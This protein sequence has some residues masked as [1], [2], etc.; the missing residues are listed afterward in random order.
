MEG[1]DYQ[2][3]LAFGSQFTL[4]TLELTPLATWGGGWHLC[5]PLTQLS[6]ELLAH[7]VYP[8]HGLHQVF[9]PELNLHG[10][11]RLQNT[12]PEQRIGKRLRGWVGRLRTDT[13]VLPAM[14]PLAP[15]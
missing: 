8:S 2:C 3:G 9:L 15:F 7:W 11:L 5:D 6:Q 13:L 14:L 1:A 4:N 10:A 12:P